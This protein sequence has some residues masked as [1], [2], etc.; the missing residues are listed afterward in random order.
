VVHHGE[1]QQLIFQGEK[2]RIS[3]PWK[4]AA[5]LAQPNGFPQ[6]EQNEALIKALNDFYTALP[7][8]AYDGHTAQ[9]DNV[10][11][12][13][14][15]GGKP[16]IGG[17]EGRLTIE[18]ITAIYKASIE[19]RKV[20]LPIGRDDLFYTTEGLEKKAPHFYQ[21]TAFAENLSGDIKT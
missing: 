21:K 2:A 1:E 17:A 10:L 15:T 18:L 7:K 20:S 4:V 6:P 14:Q 5:H 9:I 13:L 19:G 8:Q 16:F 3:F 12:A 11:T